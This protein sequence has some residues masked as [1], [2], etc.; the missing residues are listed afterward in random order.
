MDLVANRTKLRALVGG[1]PSGRFAD[2][3]TTLSRV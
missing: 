3:A 2:C 1:E